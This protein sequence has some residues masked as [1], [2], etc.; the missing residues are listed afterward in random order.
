MCSPSLPGEAGYYRVRGKLGRGPAGLE[1]SRNAPGRRFASLPWCAQPSFPQYPRMC[2]RRH[3]PCS[4]GAGTVA[5]EGTRSPSGGACGPFAR[6]RAGSMTDI[7]TSGMSREGGRCCTIRIGHGGKDRRASV[8]QKAQ[9][10]PR[11]SRH[12]GPV[13]GDAGKVYSDKIPFVSNTGGKMIPAYLARW[14]GRPVSQ[15]LS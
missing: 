5:P 7:M 4:P 3:V 9:D 11:E 2:R 12:A 10:R 8:S 1:Q 14:E 15:Q 13:P 6:K